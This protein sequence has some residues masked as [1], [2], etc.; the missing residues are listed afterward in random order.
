LR[1]I[2]PPSIKS[3]D[4]YWGAIPW[5]VLQVIMVAILIAWPELVTAFLDADI[6]VDP[7]FEMTVPDAG[8][9]L[10]PG[11]PAIDLNTAPKIE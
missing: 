8:T 3:S 7:N 10:E 2:A 1:G 9:G 6:V 11:A 4:I 5:V